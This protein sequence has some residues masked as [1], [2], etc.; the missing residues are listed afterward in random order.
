MPL[1]QGMDGF[2]DDPITF[3]V[4]VCVAPFRPQMLLNREGRLQN[5]R[6]VVRLKVV[7]AQRLC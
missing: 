2:N 3:G 5:A 1:S 7:V 4:L 6:F